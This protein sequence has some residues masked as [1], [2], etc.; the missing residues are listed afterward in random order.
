MAAIGKFYYPDVGI[1]ECAELVRVINSEF[2]GETSRDLLALKLGHSGNSGRL[3]SKLSALRQFGLIEGHGAI[4]LTDLGLSL[5][6]AATPEQR[7]VW[8]FQAILKV[9]LLSQLY[10]RFNATG[11]E[12]AALTDS[13]QTIT[14]LGRSDV[15]RAIPSVSRHL[16]QVTSW[17]NQKANLGPLSQHVNTSLWEYQDRWDATQRRLNPMRARSPKVNE[18]IWRHGVEDGLPGAFSPQSRERWDPAG[19]EGS[20]E[21]SRQSLD[22]SP[23]KDTNFSSI[24]IEV[25]GARLDVP[26]TREGVTMAQDFLNSLSPSK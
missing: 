12:S 6:Q 1:D 26:F 22:P 4:K 10:E 17:S 20:A 13:M 19:V 9:P 14:G 8:K 2:N 5:A 24:K 23:T 3:S 21:S 25:H 7:I 11:V 16:D 15:E 18:V